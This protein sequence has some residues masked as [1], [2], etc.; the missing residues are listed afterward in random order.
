MAR[1]LVGIVSSDKA[2]KTIS[3]TVTTRKTHPIYKKQFSVSKKFLAH[4]EKNEAKTGDKVAIVETRPQS[5]KKRFALK[6]VIERPV[7]RAEDLKV[8][9]VEEEVVKKVP[10]KT[11]VTD[12]QTEQEAGEA[13]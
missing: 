7:L 9:G 4:D 11:E 5:A 13:K 1:Q 8:E 10:K 12:D 2:D 6:E 3:V